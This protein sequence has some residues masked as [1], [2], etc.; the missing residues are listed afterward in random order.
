MLH[1]IYLQIGLLILFT[2]VHNRSEPSP[3]FH[4][5][6]A[7]TEEMYAHARNFQLSSNFQQAKLK[8]ASERL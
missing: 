1:M 3:D 2:T 7:K 4:L 6:V 5:K 8:K